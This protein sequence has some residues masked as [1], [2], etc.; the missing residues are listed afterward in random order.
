MDEK[1][2]FC[3]NIKKLRESHHL[4]K[5]EMS[6]RLKISMRTLNKLESGELP[7]RLTVKIIYAIV[8]EFDMRA[9]DLFN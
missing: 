4:T 5:T 1:E 7:K 2:K 9:C 3:R 6:R 8:D